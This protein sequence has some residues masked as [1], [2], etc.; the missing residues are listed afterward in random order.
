MQL[1]QVTQTG[2]AVQ[3]STTPIMCRI[4]VVQNNAAAVAHVGDSTVSTTKGIQ[5]AASGAANS[6][7]KI[8][9]PVESINIAQYYTIGTSTQ[10]LDVMYEQ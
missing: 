5:L 7:L 2:A 8:E 1:I 6:I 4:L 9:S 3:L 10:L